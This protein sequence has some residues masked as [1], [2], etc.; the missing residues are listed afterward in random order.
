[1]T[2]PIGI[3]R[4]PRYERQMKKNSTLGEYSKFQLWPGYM[5]SFNRLHEM[6]T[7]NTSP[8]LLLSNLIVGQKSL[9]I[10]QTLSYIRHVEALWIYCV[11]RTNNI[12]P[13]Y[14]C[15]DFWNNHESDQYQYN[16][17]RPDQSLDLLAYPL[18]RSSYCA[19]NSLFNH[20]YNL[21]A[22]Y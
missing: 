13:K 8:N 2:W 21:L 14:A 16:K 1:M 19:I 15:Q 12:M 6:K 3:H 17:I 7:G 4:I 22:C 11:E 10:K 20:L 9:I 5:R 18:S